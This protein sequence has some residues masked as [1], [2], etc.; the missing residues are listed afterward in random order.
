MGKTGSKWVRWS[1]K[2]KDAFLDHLA[3]TCNVKE[4]AATAGVP[5][6]SVY[7]LRRKDARFLEQWGEA[8]ALG[9]EVLE[10]RAVGHALAGGG[11]RIADQG[12]GEIDIDL[13]LHLL[14][15]HRN[16]RG[17]PKR[18]GRPVMRATREETDRA[19]LK[20]L[21]AYERRIQEGK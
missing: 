2:K 16:A 7:A 13:A 8:L 1:Q 10:T 5:L 11:R 3:A 4:S 15:V 17:K 6:G 19:I 12:F 14:Q 20:K 18:D 9:Y 21:D